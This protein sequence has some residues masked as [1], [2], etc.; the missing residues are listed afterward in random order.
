MNTAGIGAG[1]QDVV[2]RKT[3]PAGIF[4]GPV[5]MSDPRA[6][7]GHLATLDRLLQ[8]HPQ[9]RTVPCL[10]CPTTLIAAIH[11]T[12]GGLCPSPWA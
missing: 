5:D 1:S 8:E 10:G 3:G 6:V 4:A 12:H 9:V 11:C 2:R 7:A